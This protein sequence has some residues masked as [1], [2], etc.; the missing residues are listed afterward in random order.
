MFQVSRTVV[1]FYPAN[2]TGRYNCMTEIE[3]EVLEKNLVED[4][5][6]SSQQARRFDD[7]I[8]EIKKE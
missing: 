6:P 4:H 7:L 3:I 8:N 5:C 1:F 2:T